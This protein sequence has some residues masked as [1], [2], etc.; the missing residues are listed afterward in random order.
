VSPDETPSPRDFEQ[1]AEETIHDG[2]IFRVVKGRFR[3]ADG[4]EH[5]REY[6]RSPGAVGIV[7]VDD[8]HVWLVRQPREALGDP[9]LL[10][11]PAGRLDKDGEPPAQTAAR[12]LEEEVGLR[13]SSIEHLKTYASS[14][15]MTDELVHL[16]LATGLERVE[17]PADSG[18][19]ERIE[20]EAWPLAELDALVD[21]VYDAK[22]LLGLLLLR[23]RLA[24]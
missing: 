2:R 9:D 12:E 16:F 6:T 24:R 7:A 3:F 19:D 22:T 14:A 11:I 4:V 5:D 13:A 10:E 1:V 8:T 20:V 15:G 23:E 21:A 18:E 17:D